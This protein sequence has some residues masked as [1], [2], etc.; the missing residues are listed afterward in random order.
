ML[1]AG[2]TE[3]LTVSRISEYGIYLADEEQYEVL[4]PNRYT[5]LTDKVGD[6]KKVFIYHDSEDR[7]VATTETPLLR[8]GEVGFLRVV[9]KTPHGAFLDWGL[10]GKDLFLPNR[11]QQG[12]VL[13]G[14]EYLV[15]L[16]EDD[17]TGRCVATE[18]LK[19][20]VNNE[21]ISVKP[22]EQVSILV[23]SESP[24][25]FRVVVNNRHWGMIYKNQLF[26]PVAIGERTEAYVR[27]I[28]D[29][30]RLDISLQQ[31]GLSQVRDSAQELLDKRRPGAHNQALMEFGALQCVPRSPDCGACPLADR[32]RALAEGRVGV[33]PV[34]AGRT[35]TRERYFHYF[36]IRRG[37]KTLLAKRTGND[38]WRNLYEFPLVETEAPLSWEELRRTEAFRALFDG[39]EE[40]CFVDAYEARKHVLSHQVIHAVFYRVEVSEFPRGM[41]RYV[42]VDRKCLGS[43][44]VSRLMES[45]LEK[46]EQWGK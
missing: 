6:K 32:C 31:E 30:N 11:N 1:K 13:V 17:I 8:V 33:L 16:Y 36:D 9:D 39:V 20:F 14:H 34:K 41:E 24:I 3:T 37:E 25:G 18:K 23:A 7:L 4:L 26:R 38:I 27:R 45:Y 29:D 40:A 42:R 2:R 19:A 15:C 10:H 46:V 44:A 28:T 12:G 35:R 21:L 43:Y 22:R 5:S